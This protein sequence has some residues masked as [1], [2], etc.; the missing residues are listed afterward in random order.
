MGQLKDEEK[1]ILQKCYFDIIDASFISSNIKAQCEAIH[2]ALERIRPVSQFSIALYN[3]EEKRLTCIFS[4]TQTSVVQSLTNQDQ[5]QKSISSSLCQQVLETQE[6]V[7]KNIDSSKKNQLSENN[8]KR[9]F[10]DSWLGLPLLQNGKVAGVFFVQSDSGEPGYSSK[11]QRIFHDLASCIS[12]TIFQKLK[13]DLLKKNEAITNAIFSISSA[14]NTTENLDELYSSIHSILSKII[15]TKNFRIVLYDADK[16]SSEFVYFVDEK[17]DTPNAYKSLSKSGAVMAEVLIKG[18]PLFFT[19]SQAQ[20]RSRRIKKDIIGTISQLWLGV[21]LKSRGKVIGAII[22][23]SYTDPHRY[24]QRD[25]DILMAV[26]DQIAL[27]IDRKTEEQKRK[28]SETI[29]GILFK[30]SSAVNMSKSLDEL[31]TAIHSALYPIM[32]VTNFFIA[33]HDPETDLLHFPYYEDEHDEYSNKFQYYLDDNSLSGQVFIQ[34]KIIMFDEKELE[35]K[36]RQNKVLGTLPKVWIGIPL[37]TKERIIGI[38]VTQKYSE[39]TLYTD[40]EVEFLNIVSNHIAVAIERKREEEALN[41][42]EN[43]NKT[44]FEISK[45]VNTAQSLEELYK[46]IHLSLMKVIQA[47]NFFISIFDKE[48]QLIRFPYFVDEYDNF[49]ASHIQ[50]MSDSSLTNL[51]FRTEKAVF[52]NKE[53]LQERADEKGLI[54]HIPVVWVGIPLK[55]NNEI[56]G[57]MVTQSYTSENVF[58]DQ[59]INLLLSVSDQVALAI[60]RKRGERKLQDS[61]AQLKKLSEQSEKLNLALTSILTMKKKETYHE[62]SKVIVDHSDYKK[63]LIFLF[64]EEFPGSELVGHAGLTPTQISKVKPHDKPWYTGI[65]SKAEQIGQLCYYLSKP[66]PDISDAY[67]PDFDGIQPDVNE[68]VWHPGDKLFV[69]MLDQDGELMGVISVEQARSKLR[70]SHATVRPLEIFS[71]LFSGVLIT[72][73]AQEELYIN[74]KMVERTNKKLVGVNKKLEHAIADANKLAEEAKAATNA[75][76]EFLANMSHEIRTPMNAIIGFSKLLYSTGLTDQQNELTGIIEQSSENLLKI[77]DDILDYS[78][79]E[80]GKLHL[81]ETQ[82]N[83]VALLDELI[84]F[85]SNAVAKRGIDLFIRYDPAIPDLILGDPIRLRQILTNLINNAIKFTEFGKVEMTIH[86]QNQEDDGMELLFKIKDTGIGIRPE[87]QEKLFDSFEQAD[88][89][90]TRKYGGT[91]LGLAICKNFIEMM[92]GTIWVESEYGEGSTFHFTSQFLKLKEQPSILST[93][94]TIH[95]RLPLHILIIKKN[96]AS[97]AHI[98]QILRGIPCQ[99]DMV[100]SAEEV[101]ELSE[102]SQYNL[103]LL[104]QEFA[105]TLSSFI[106]RLQLPTAILTDNDDQVFIE[107]YKELQQKLIYLKQPLKQS[108]LYNSILNSIGQEPRQVASSEQANSEV[109]FSPLHGKHILIVEDNTINCQVVKVVLEN[110][111]M[112]TDI[113][114]NGAEALL[115]A[116]EQHYDAILMDVQMPEMDG[117]E[118]TRK[119][120]QRETVEQRSPVPIIALTAHAMQ[121]DKEKCLAAGMT[122]YITKPINN[123]LMLET[124]IQ[125]TDNNTS[126]EQQLP[127]PAKKTVTASLP[128]SLDGIDLKAALTRVEGNS[129]LLKE[130]LI[131]FDK[132]CQQSVLKINQATTDNDL[133]LLLRT[134]H[135]IKGMAG[136]L[137]VNTVFNHAKETEKAIKKHNLIESCAF[138]VARFKEEL[139]KIQATIQVLYTYEEQ[140]CSDNSIDHSKA[141][142]RMKKLLHLIQDSDLESIDTAQRLGATIPGSDKLFESLQDNLSAFDFSSA[143]SLLLQLAEKYHI[144]LGTQNEQ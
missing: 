136:N 115:I 34:K 128:D 52:L 106:V 120:R 131:E 32:D 65:F 35:E 58:S 114:S 135:T 122:D 68:N 111:K 107:E 125:H 87:Q 42:S 66:H 129:S 118:A 44:I 57:A 37:R 30:I 79:I 43:V 142:S 93:F 71:S 83:L 82:F 117:Y 4:H 110:N 77:I 126:S 112:T 67:P 12:Q 141:A 138:A 5:F 15:D 3:K 8:K 16:D 59:D 2:K 14:V 113:A 74:R 1:S 109:D 140:V 24:S 124:I 26:S 62:I 49:S 89:S 51:V 99:L 7:L 105:Q 25:A 56:I 69:K 46:T 18:E 40:K 13:E 81:E 101:R 98:Q 11:D 116:F 102:F 75:K 23:Q 80:A 94:N 55:V 45:A 130:L 97:L 31:Y 17:N 28:E 10:P 47:T 103:I 104:D 41:K 139:I 88:G 127:A 84:D 33:L 123:R 39:T 36:G 70:P 137:S 61:E 85:F 72:K 60:D 134:I 48:N 78:K 144:D 100:N 50:S 73:Q 90:T 143:E 6:P 29:T 54:G 121:G 96:S 63:V 92:G 27:A 133:D 9:Q 19:A 132:Q 95:D 119:I 108:H 86:I 38:M 91:G 76:S 64:T 20:E 21:P 22:V 53:Q